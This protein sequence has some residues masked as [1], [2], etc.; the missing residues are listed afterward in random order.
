MRVFFRTVC[1][2]ALLAVALC[3]LASAQRE[4]ERDRDWGGP[5]GRARG[6][7]ERVQRDLERAQTMAPVAGKQAER[8]DNAH[9]HLSQFDDRLN[10]GEFD[11]DKLDQAI[12]DVN[13]VLKNNV[14][15]RQSRDRL[16]DDL[17]ALRG[18]RAARGRI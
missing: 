14:V 7:V 17:D 2:V 9:R 3:P 4:R 12:D 10:Q 15:S 18:L 11:K 5:Y 13:N 8:Y 1:F 16:R 6:L